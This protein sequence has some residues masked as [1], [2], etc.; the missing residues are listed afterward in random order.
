[1]SYER[2]TASNNMGYPSTAYGGSTA[3]AVNVKGLELGSTGGKGTYEV[4]YII[5][6]AGDSPTTS[7]DD[8]QIV[9]IPAS[10][11]IKRA[12]VQV[13]ETVSGGTNFSIG[14]AEP[15]GSVID[16]DGLTAASTVT[17]VGSFVEGTGAL[18]GS[19][20]GTASG[21]LTLGGTRTAGKIKVTLEYL[22]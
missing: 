5:D 10:A 20:I 7:E 3:D 15:D 4:Q 13:L 6:F 16:A 11:A 8:N 1:M 14:L 17:A 2:K 19:T 12:D 9:T 21:Q 18:V 22:V